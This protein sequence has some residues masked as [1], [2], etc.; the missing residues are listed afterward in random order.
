M[1][2]RYASRSGS[3]ERHAHG[4]D[5]LRLAERPVSGIGIGEVYG[6]L[7]E[8]EEC[9]V[10]MYQNQAQNMYLLYLSPKC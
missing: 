10:Q 8:V 2:D 5:C 1:I 9:G 4:W 7:G 6:G 3:V